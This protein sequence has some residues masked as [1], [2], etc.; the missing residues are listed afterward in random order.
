MGHVHIAGSIITGRQGLL[1][2]R[3]ALGIGH[4][5]RESLCLATYASVGHAIT[6]SKVAGGGRE[7]RRTK[8]GEDKFE[9]L[10]MGLTV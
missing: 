10:A 8:E 9:A 6:L 4:V 5:Y 2:L 1:T 3:K 7:P